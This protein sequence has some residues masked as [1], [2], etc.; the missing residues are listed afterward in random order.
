MK[1]SIIILIFALAALISCNDTTMDA[2]NTPQGSVE[3]TSVEFM[4]SATRSSSQNSRALGPEITSPQ[5]L[6][7]LIGD[8]RVMVFDNTGKC[9]SYADFNPLRLSL[10]NKLRMSVP[11]GVNDFIFVTN[12]GKEQVMSTNIKGKTSDELLLFLDTMQMA[13]TI[14]FKQAQH[15]FFGQIDNVTVVAN[16]ASTPVYNVSLS[17]MVSQLD[18]RVHINQVWKD[19]AKTI[20][21]RNYIKVMRSNVVKFISTDISMSKKINT[22]PEHRYGSDTS[23]IV[24]NSWQKIENDTTAR[25]VTIAFPTVGMN[26]RPALLLAAEVSPT[27]PGFVADPRD[28]ILPNGNVI[29]Y[30]WYQIQNYDFR[31]NVRLLLTI[32][33]LIGQG[34][35]VPPPPDVEATVEFTITVKDWDS[36]IDNEGGNKDDFN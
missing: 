29:R 36:V 14:Y 7:S 20:P 1:P 2:T 30:W 32:T 18:T 24:N 27:A 17:R 19:A 23:V 15:H 22:D 28:Q 9:S 6:D 13:G 10:S 5:E 21:M 34:S 3:M 11:T 12:V 8:M 26:T 33:A 4:V 16:P 31:E 25:N 35:P